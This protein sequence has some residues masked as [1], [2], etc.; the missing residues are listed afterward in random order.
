MVLDHEPST[1]LTLLQEAAE[2]A[3]NIALRHLRDGVTA[4]EKPDNLGPVTDADLEI[5]AMLCE[6]LRGDRPSYG[7]MSEESP[8]DPARLDAERVFIIDPIDGTRAFIKGEQGFSIALAVVERGKPIAA[9]VHLPARGETYT[10]ARGQGACLNGASLSVS[11]QA[12]L[13]EA[14]VLTS[15]QQM[16]PK[17]WPGGVPPLT[18]HFR[19][20]L[21]WRMCLVA[22]ANFDTMLTFRDAFE[23]DIAAGALIAE[24][25]GA[26]VT[27]GQGTPLILNSQ[28]GMQPGLIVA[29]PTLHARIMTHRGGA[30]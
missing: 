27:D 29:P 13:D 12:A 20:S 14:T 21:A 8:P 28:A 18:Q 6:R 25:A 10:A 23:W 17:H 9:A 11:K 2:A 26:M 30:V 22:A 1:D 7:W 16:A 4:T 24:E 15:R 5:D 3:G 19:S